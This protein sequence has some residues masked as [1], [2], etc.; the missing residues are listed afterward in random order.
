VLLLLLLLRILRYWSRRSPVVSVFG[1]AA[2]GNTGISSMT[3]KGLCPGSISLVPGTGGL[4]TGITVGATRRKMER[5]LRLKTRGV[6]SRGVSKRGAKWFLGSR[7][8][9]IPLT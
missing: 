1:R 3:Y 8:R 9:N 2:V 7:G 5:R 6:R 4:R